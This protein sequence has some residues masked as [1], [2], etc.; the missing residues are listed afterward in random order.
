MGTDYR[1]LDDGND[2][3]TILGKS[4]SSL[5][6]VFGATPAD[7]AAHITSV[8]TAAATTSTPYGYAASTQ[9]DAIVTAVNAILVAI[10]DFGVVAKA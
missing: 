10:E 3:G 5:I 4:S 2:D 9:A 1:Y 7:Q 6:S 8:S